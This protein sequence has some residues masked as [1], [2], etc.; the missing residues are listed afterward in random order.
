MKKIVILGELLIISTI[1]QA[2]EK[3]SDD[4]KIRPNILCITCE[5]IS[6]YLGCYGDAVAVSPNIDHFSKES[7]LYKGMYTTIGVSA[8]ARASLITGM[9]P[10]AIGANNMRTAQNKSKPEGITPYDVVL[11]EGVKCFTELLRSAGYYCTNNSKTDYQFQS[12]LTAWDECSDSAHWKN[13]PENIRFFSIFNLTVTHEFEIMKRAGKPL[14][15]K[16]EQIVVPDY[17]PDNAIVRNDMAIMYSNITEMDRQFQ[18]IMDELKASGE[19]DNTIIIFYS[20]NGGPLPRQKREL[21]E[22]G[23]NVPFI[24]RFPDK[25]Y[26]GKTDT[27]LHMFVDIPATILSLAGIRPPVY[28]QGIPFL[29]KYKGEDRKYVYGARDRLDTFYEKQVSVRDHRY[30]YIRNYKPEQSC[31]LP[32]IS[33]SPMPI[34]KEMVRLHHAGQLLPGAEKWFAKP[35]PVE[36]LYDVSA[37]PYELKNL[38]EDVSYKTIMNRLSKEQDRWIK[39]ENPLWKYTEPELIEM[40]WPGRIQPVTASPEIIVKNNLVKIKCATGG[41]SIAYQINGKGYVKDH[42]FLYTKPFRLNPGDVVTAVATRAG[43]AQSVQVKY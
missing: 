39:E 10:T 41:A 35:R 40:F 21:Y 25:M 4:K 8:P 20:D 1:T 16:P 7:I 23:S 30:R 13:K 42:W 26:A 12:P 24:V 19:L 37:D 5:D 14:T 27:Q 15:V 6:P 17:F 2:S 38:A 32:I 28:M 18:I 34:V 36:E 29:G 43:Y 3:K 11:P 22:S 31:Y 33:R 9:Y